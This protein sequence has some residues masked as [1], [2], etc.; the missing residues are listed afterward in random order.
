MQVALLL[1]MAQVG[2]FVPADHFLFSPRDRIFSRMGFADSVE[3]N[4]SSFV[5]EMQEMTYILDH[6]TERRL[7]SVDELGRATSTIDGES[8]AWAVSEKLLE[9]GCY[10]LIATHFSDLPYLASLYPGIKCTSLS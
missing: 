7:V 8:I 4:S 10:S 1:I 3:T 6:V 9:L 5:V 2:S